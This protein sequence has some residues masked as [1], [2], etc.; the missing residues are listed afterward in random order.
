MI[1]GCINKMFND[2]PEN[3]TCDSSIGVGPKNE[4]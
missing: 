3:R 4:K 2:Y 1:I